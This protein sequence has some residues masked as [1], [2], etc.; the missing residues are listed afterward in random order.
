M[1]TKSFAKFLNSLI[2]NLTISGISLKSYSNLLLFISDLWLQGA[3]LEFSP[4][5]I[6]QFSFILYIFFNWFFLT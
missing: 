1:N 6:R 4:L 3:L 2:S 5:T